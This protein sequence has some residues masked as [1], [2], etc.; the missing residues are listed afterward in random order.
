VGF[1]RLSRNEFRFGCCRISGY[2]AANAS[3]AFGFAA[4]IMKSL[5]RGTIS[6][7]KRDPLNTP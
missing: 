5:M 2:S 4:D 1:G 7:R 3:E 6:D